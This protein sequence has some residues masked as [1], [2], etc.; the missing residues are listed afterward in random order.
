M[1]ITISN[2]VLSVIILFLHI[3]FSFSQSPKITYDKDTIKVDGNFYAIMKKKSAGALINDFSVCNYFGVELIYFRV[4]FRKVY[5][6]APKF[7]YGDNNTEAYHEINFINSRGKAVLLDYLTAKNAA[8]FVVENNLIKDNAVNPDAES[9]VMQI[10][11]GKYPDENNSYSQYNNVTKITVSTVGNSSS[12]NDQPANNNTTNTKSK[13]PIILNGNQ[14]MRDG[15][16][17]GKYRTDTN[18]SNYSQ[19]NLIITIYSELG[20]KVAE[21]TAPLNN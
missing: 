8:K 5:D 15:S 10:Y 6:R 7:S 20:E 16:V 12:N 14:I 11:Y 19:Q 17:I 3:N 9:R 21:A 18:A 1:K 13:S 2:I 4:R